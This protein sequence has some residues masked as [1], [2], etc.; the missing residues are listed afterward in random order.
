[1]TITDAIL[2][3]VLKVPASVWTVAVEP[4]GRI[5]D[6]ACVV[7]LHGDCLKGRPKGM[8]PTVRKE[9]PHPGAQLR[10]TDADGTR[11][12]CIAIN[13][14]NT[15]SPRWKCVT[16]SA[17]AEDRHPR[18]PYTGLRNLPLHDQPV[19][20]GHRILRLAHRRDSR[21]LTLPTISPTHRNGTPVALPSRQEMARLMTADTTATQTPSPPAT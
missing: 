1:M 11:L 20:T 10:F 13:I 7:D 16:A 17:R 18:R 21:A 4:C 9:R 5:R 6:G 3:A 2:Q 19:T 8:R 14:T 12:T 15:P